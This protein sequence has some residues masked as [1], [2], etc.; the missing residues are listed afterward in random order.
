VPGAA[1]AYRRGTRI[2][3]RDPLA[4]GDLAVDGADLIESGVPAGPAI[5]AT[6]K[7]LLDIVIE[8][9]SQNQRDALMA[10]VRSSHSG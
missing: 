10:I 3:F 1:T 4:V 8:D 5:G 2:A 9:P 7:R 6:L